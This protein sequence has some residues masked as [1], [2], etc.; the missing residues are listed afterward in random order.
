MTDKE[1]LKEIPVVLAHK[2]FWGV[3][4]TTPKM[5]CYRSTSPQNLVCQI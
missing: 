2:F 5:L 1:F 4:L 3:C